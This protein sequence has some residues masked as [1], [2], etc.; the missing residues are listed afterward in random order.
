MGSNVLHAAVPKLAGS[1]ARITAQTVRRVVVPGLLGLLLF[2]AAAKAQV[3]RVDATPGHATNSF[4]PPYALG[5]TVDRVPSNATDIFFRPDQLKQ[6]LSAGWGTVSYRQNTE[7]FVQAWHW[8]PKGRWSDPSGKGYFS[9]SAVPAADGIRHSYGYSLQHR[10]FTRNGGTEF[11]GFSRLDDGDLNTYWKSNPYLTKPFTGE[12]DSLHPQWVVIDL[13]KKQ[14]VNAIR[15]AWAEPYARVY[16]VEYWTGEDAMDDQGHGDWKKFESGGVTDGKAGTVTLP[17]GPASARFVRVLMTESSG[18]CD[19]HG[20]SDRRNCLGY[21]IREIYLGT[22][23][24]QGNFK[25]L[26][27]HSPDQKQSL[28]YCSSV[29]PWHE[30][31]DLYVAPDRM[32]SGDQPGL[33]L[34]YTSGI[35]RGLPAVIPVAML[36]GTPEDS[37][38][39]MTYLKQRGYPVWYVEMGEEPDGNTCSLKITARSIC[40]GRRRCMARIRR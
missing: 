19:T 5:T 12:D 3:V 37:V 7:L 4:S 16:Q 24:S 13:G 29:D 9:G 30:S 40:N 36:Y 27:Q 10:G 11:D 26:L 17:L 21:A 20:A 32:E 39:Q 31:S 35:T 6:V 1:W 8:N 22:A 23:D 14:D 33:D 28:T 38:A 34:F 15:I 25:D 2:A 18:T